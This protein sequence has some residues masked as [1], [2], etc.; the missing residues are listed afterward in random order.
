M[1]NLANSK[2][3]YKG[4]LHILLCDLFQGRLTAVWTLRLMKNA[5][6][7]LITGLSRLIYCWPW[8]AI[9]ALA[10]SPPC[11]DSAAPI[12]YQ[13]F[14]PAANSGLAHYY[15]SL[16]LSEGKG[17]GAPVRALVM[18]HGL[19]RDADNAFTIGLMATRRAGQSKHTLVVAPVF[20]VAGSQAAKCRSAGVPAAGPGDLLWTC[21]S[22]LAGG[23]ASNDAAISS[24]DMLDALISTLKKRW[25]SLQTVTVAGFSA[26]GQLV[27]HYIGFAADQPGLSLRYVVADPGTWLYFDRYRPLPPARCPAVNQWK[28]GTEN[29]PVNLG[30]TAAQARRHYAGADIHY[31]EGAADDSAGKGTFYRI[32]DKSCAA[33]AQGPYRM[34]R[35]LAYAGYDRTLLSPDK[36]RTVT[37]LAGCAHDMACVFSARSA[38]WAL[39]GVR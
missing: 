3:I 20:Q 17:V 32:L 37:L 36:K 13:Q 28:Y 15:S 9:P 33:Q 6:A 24:F 39:F 10:A 26:G 8:F 14:Q 18:V 23:G 11:T 1:A 30:K 38:R 5:L 7:A 12:C 25:P 34:Q 2:A 21:Q 27:Q 4:K 19:P 29:L 35:G 22:W 31:L 16:A